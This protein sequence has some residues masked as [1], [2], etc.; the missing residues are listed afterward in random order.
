MQ[1]HNIMDISDIRRLRLREWLKDRS[2]P[3]KERSYFSQLL[4]GKAP[5]GVR[6]AR[7]LERDYK[8]GEMYLDKPG[9]MD[10]RKN[11][12][13]RASNIKCLNQ[14]GIGSKNKD[15]EI[16]P[17]TKGD[18]VPFVSYEQINKI[19]N[20]GVR[21]MPDEII[22][23]LPCPV[24]HG[25]DT[26]A[27]KIRG[28]SMINTSDGHPSFRDGELVYVDPDV[29][30]GNGSFVLAMSSDKKEISVRKLLIEGERKFLVTLNKAWPNSVIELNN[31]NFSICGVIIFKGE[32]MV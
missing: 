31:F 1:H 14:N 9:A 29:K 5:F 6:A 13:R 25:Q 27:L 10:R 16:G 19:I 2:L 30:P 12:D 15:V 28:E 32:S 8:M 21:L 7:R 23:W 17:E 22:D 4:T 3:E 26:Y 11:D 20:N 18:K 24:C